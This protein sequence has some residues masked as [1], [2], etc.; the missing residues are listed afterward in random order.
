MSDI[1]KIIS[2]Q[3]PNMDGWAS[4]EKCNILAKLVLAEKPE[5]CILIGVYAGRD[6]CAIALALKENNKGVVIGIDPW[7]ASE[8]VKG[9]NEEHTAWW[10]KAPHDSVLKKCVDKIKEFQIEGFAKLVRSTSDDYTPPS[11]VDLV[12]V[13][14][15]HGEQAIKDIIKF[16]PIIKKGGYILLDDISWPGGAVERAIMILFGLGFMWHLKVKNEN[17]DYAI[18]KRI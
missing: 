15:N 4:V 10:S 3:I 2:E 5:T 12:I 9:Q 17:E 14:G 1:F 18:L 13:D 6:L 16:A 8:S 7:S 11:S